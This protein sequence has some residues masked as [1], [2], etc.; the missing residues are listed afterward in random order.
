MLTIKDLSFSTEEKNIIKNIGYDF[1]PGKIYAILGNNGVGKSTLVKIIMGM[2]G[3]FK[4]HGGTIFFE[5][6]DITELSLVERAKLGI[7]ITNQEPARFKGI[8]VEAY[9]KLGGKNSYSDKEII[10]A[11][12]TVGLNGIYRFRKVDK[13]LSGGERKRIE[14]AS[15]LLIKPKVVIF[16]EPD[17][18]ID[19]M[20]N[21][22]LADVIKKLKEK[23]STVIIITHREEISLLADVALLLCNGY[24]RDVGDPTR[25]NKLYKETCDVCGHVNR[26]INEEVIENDVNWK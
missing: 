18:G 19:M 2:N 23:N 16:D 20:S 15:I 21:S 9:L 12:R 10:D 26:P 17:S 4:N 5:N 13:T 14:L 1:K 6:N 25:I 11:L 8:S 7:T 24:I 22:M 3:Y